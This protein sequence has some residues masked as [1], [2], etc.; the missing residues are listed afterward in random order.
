MKNI[1]KYKDVLLNAETDDLRCCVIDLLYK[2]KCP[3]NCKVCKKKV[4]EWLLSDYKNPV[5][6]EKEKEYLSSVIKPF[7][8]HVTSVRK[9]FNGIG[10]QIIISLDHGE[11]LCRLPG[12]QLNSEMY[13]GMDSNKWYSLQELGL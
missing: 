6:D 2:G 3:D 1:E 5:L 9:W 7:R 12:F 8:N 13:K 10:Y 4:I 11:K